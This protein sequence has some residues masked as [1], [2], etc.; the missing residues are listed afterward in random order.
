MSTRTIKHFHI[1]SNLCRECRL[2]V[3]TTRKS[4][5]LERLDDKRHFC[6]LRCAAAYG[7]AKSYEALK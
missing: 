7:V 3:P 4:E 1:T 2:S 6:S 5:T